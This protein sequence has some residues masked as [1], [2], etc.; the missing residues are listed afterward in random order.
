MSFSTDVI[1]GGH[2]AIIQKAAA[3]GRL[4][5]GV[6]AD[7]VVATYKRF[8]L[9][10]TQDRMSIFKNIVGVHDV[11]RQV[12]PSGVEIIQALRPDVVVHG[13]DW[14][15][16]FRSPIRQAVIE[17]LAQYGGRLVEYPSASSRGYDTFEKQ[18]YA[19]LAIPDIRRGRLKRLLSLKP[20]VRA[21]E[22]S[23]GL[24]GLLVEDTKVRVG[25]KVEQF[26]AMWLSS[27]CDS[28]AKGK[29]DIEVV[30]FSSR[31]R[32]VEDIL[33]VTTKPIIFDA[34]TG[35]QAEHFAYMMRTLE[36]IGV[37]AA[38]VEDKTGL[39]RNSLF[40]AAAEQTQDGI[41]SFCRKIQTGKAA[42][43]TKDTMIIARI[44]SLI[45][46]RGQEDAL[47]RA[48]AY[49]GAGADGI[50][51]HS[52]KK[53]P[54][55]IFAF[56]EKFR[57]RY[58]DLP[59]VVVP[60]TY[61]SVYEAELACRGVNLVIYANQLTRSAFPAMRKTAA[62]ILENGRALEADSF[63]LPIQEIIRLIP[64]QGD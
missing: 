61:P 27:L 36:R 48:F 21:M 13:D 42:L 35:G 14:R 19:S 46:E 51:I 47:A 15:T 24:M 64:E 58:D 7:E 39:K 30:D 4:T 53:S 31:I 63:C 5:V 9:L 11:V 44:E 25:D 43:K 22:A 50:M 16:D 59:L 20:L 8:P 62:S 52:K 26:D 17:A 37:S 45:L 33:E 56:C 54:D 40:G 41:E 6:I 49:A 3:L 10:T 2:I 28:T 29:P 23:S 18:A 60:S 38:I 34:D 12:S 57:G 55:E 32:T 1:H